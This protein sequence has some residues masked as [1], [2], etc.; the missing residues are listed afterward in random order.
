MCCDP[1]MCNVRHCTSCSIRFQVH[2]WGLQRLVTKAV[3]GTRGMPL[4]QRQAK[5]KQRAPLPPA[6]PRRKANQ[7]LLCQ[8]RWVAVKCLLL[9]PLCF[10][11]C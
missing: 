8:H 11:F 1:D 5:R 3:G 6:Q 7:R 2:T 9:V 4:H 10:M